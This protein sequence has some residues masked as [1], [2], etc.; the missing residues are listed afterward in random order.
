MGVSLRQRYHR[1]QW[2]YARLY[3]Y[4]IWRL[5]MRKLWLCGFIVIV[6]VSCGQKEITFENRTSEEKWEIMQEYYMVPDA[7]IS[8]ERPLPN[9]LSEREVLLKAADHAIAEGVLDPSYYAYQDNPTL[10]DAKIETPILMSDASTGVPN[11][12]LL[13]AVDA[14]G[15]SLALIS[16]SSARDEGE[17][18]FVRGRFISEAGFRPNNHIITKREAVELIQSQFPDSTISEPMAIDN[19]RLKDKR[20]SHQGIFWY[21]AVSETARSV[22]G[23]A[24]EYILDPFIPVIPGSAIPEVLSNRAA[25]NQTGGPHLDGYRMAKLDKPLRLFDKLETA[26]AAGGVSFAPSTYPSESVGFTPVPLK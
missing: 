7:P 3:A 13:N 18:T 15:I 9:V 12:Y 20:Y 6:F 11:I 8:D 24:G 10:M 25:L 16:V 2:G 14:D 21:F 5:T 4:G 26:R 19:L 23:E 22:A 1:S 17:S